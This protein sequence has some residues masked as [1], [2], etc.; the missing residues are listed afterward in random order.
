[1]DVEIAL[2]NRPLSYLED[3]VQ[4][5]V[6]TPNSMLHINPNYLPELKAHHL[7]ETDLRR[8]AKYLDKCKQAMWSRWTREYVRSLREQNRRA[9]REQTPHPDVGDVVI[10]KDEQK[11]RNQWKLAIVAELIKWRD[12]ITRAAKLKSSK[13]NLERAIQHLYPLELTCDMQQMVPLN[14]TVPPFKPRHKRD[15]AAAAEL[16]IQQVVG[17]EQNEH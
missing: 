1:M 2:N 10:I 9:G 7:Q 3:D 8:Q 17:E 12:N 13:G 11:N 6:L 5:P 15:A 16:R 4:L 14:P